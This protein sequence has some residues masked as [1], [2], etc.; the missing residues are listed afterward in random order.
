MGHQVAIEELMYPVSGG[1][2]K[3]NWLEKSQ[4]RAL[5]SRFTQKVPK[6][7]QIDFI[8]LVRGHHSISLA[9]R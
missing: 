5:Q 7:G 6:R 4:Q 8:D 9:R 3:L 1:E 2:H